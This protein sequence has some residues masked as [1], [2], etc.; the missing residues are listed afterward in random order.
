MELHRIETN[1]R[2]AASALAPEEEAVLS[3]RT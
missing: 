2:R 1:T 3:K